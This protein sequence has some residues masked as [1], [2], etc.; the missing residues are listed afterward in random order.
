MRSLLDANVL[1]ALFDEEHVFNDRAHAWLETH[2]A[3][4]IATCPVTENALVRI[5][6]HP[7]YSK[8]L[9]CTPTELI[10]AL[11]DFV[12]DHDHE[13]WADDLSL[14]SNEHFAPERML[15]SR[16]ITDIYLLSLATKHRARLVTFDER[17][18]LSAVPG[19]QKQHLHII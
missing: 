16:Q 9:R 1:I 12:K 8:T 13:F 7:N 3:D 11:T 5:L 19:A 2:A 14:R 10:E 15:G 4:G 6:S 17:I 18:P